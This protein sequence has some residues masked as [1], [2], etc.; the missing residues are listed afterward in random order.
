MDL[1]S[2][3]SPSSTATLVISTVVSTGVCGVLSESWKQCD[4]VIHAGHL[5]LIGHAV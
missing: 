2:L 3:G 4:D 5:Q 1:N